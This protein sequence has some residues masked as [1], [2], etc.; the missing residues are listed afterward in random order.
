MLSLVLGVAL[1]AAVV[2]G[3]WRRGRREAEAMVAEAKAFQALRDQGAYM[4]GDPPVWH[5]P[6]RSTP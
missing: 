6:E 5:L 4:M 3:G 2:L 1:C